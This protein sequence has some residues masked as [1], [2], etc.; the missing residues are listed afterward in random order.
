MRE[1]VY[2]DESA[3]VLRGNDIRLSNNYST[4]LYDRVG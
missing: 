2:G 3:S 1:A 4:Q